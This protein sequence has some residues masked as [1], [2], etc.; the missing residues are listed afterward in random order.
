ML[1]VSGNQETKSVRIMEH[2]GTF[3]C[4]KWG[5]GRKDANL[6]LLIQSLLGGGTSTSKVSYF[7]PIIPTQHP[8]KSTYSDEIQLFG[9]IIGYITDV[10]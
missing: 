3:S 6:N 1:I 10:A 4:V 5:L 9:Y 8:T 7:V 2:P